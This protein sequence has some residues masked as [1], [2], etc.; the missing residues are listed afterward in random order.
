MIHR[1]EVNEHIGGYGNREVITK[2]LPGSGGGMYDREKTGKRELMINVRR[3][4]QWRY[5]RKK[6]NRFDG[7]IM[8]SAR[9]S[10]RLRARGD[11][12]GR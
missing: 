9:A 1:E 4:R 11:G 2:R 3:K 12:V 6:G 5:E 10:G 7:R 8:W